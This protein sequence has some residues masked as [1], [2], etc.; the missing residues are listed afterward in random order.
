MRQLN[1]L[2]LYSVTD[3][4][5]GCPL[6]LRMWNDAELKSG[7]NRATK[8]INAIALASATQNKGWN[9]SAI[10]EAGWTLNNAG[11]KVTWPVDG[12]SDRLI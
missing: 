3:A 1:I 9:N 4:D 5:I 6:L 7:Y 10:G 2:E 8:G 11:D 12:I